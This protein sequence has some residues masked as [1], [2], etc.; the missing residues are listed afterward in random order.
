MSLHPSNIAL[1]RVHIGG[2]EN[3]TDKLGS[4]VPCPCRACEAVGAKFALSVEVCLGF[5]SCCCCSCCCSSA[6]LFCWCPSGAVHFSFF[7]FLFSMFSFF[8]TFLLPCAFESQPCFWAS[9]F[10]PCWKPSGLSYRY[11]DTKMFGK[12][13]LD[14]REDIDRGSAPFLNQVYLRCTH[15]KLAKAHHLPT[16]SHDEMERSSTTWRDLQIW[17]R[18]RSRCWKQLNTTLLRRTTPTE[19]ECTLQTYKC[20]IIFVSVMNELTDNRYPKERTKLVQAE[21]ALENSTSSRRL[22]RQEIV[23]AKRNSSV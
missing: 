15:Q 11:V 13:N 22:I 20:R 23:T 18:Q 2:W 7:F 17:V 14:L 16:K 21:Q 4:R 3:V 1:V 9:F 6:L 10:Q 5:V 8:Y 12:K 19:K